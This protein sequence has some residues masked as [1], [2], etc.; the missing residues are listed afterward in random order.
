M[1][2]VFTSQREDYVRGKFIQINKEAILKNEPIVA[3]EYKLLS[4]GARNPFRNTIH[5]VTGDIYFGDVGSAVWEEINMIPNPLVNEEIVNFGW[6]CVEGDDGVSDMYQNYLRENRIDICNKVYRGDFNK[7]LFHYRFGPVDPDFP[8]YC[9]DA[10]AS[11]SGMTFYTGNKLPVNFKNSLF[12]VDYGKK[13]VFNFVNGPD[14]NPIFTQAHAI[15]AGEAGENLGGFTDIKT[16]NDGYLYVADYSGGSLHRLV[17]ADDDVKVN[18]LEEDDDE[19]IPGLKLV[20]DT[21]PGPYEW[22]YGQKVDYELH[23]NMD[24]PEDAISW[25][26]TNGHC[27]KNPC[28]GKD[29]C[30]FHSV[31]LSEESRKGSKG[32]FN[33][34][35]HPM[36]SFILITATIQ[37]NGKVVTKEFITHSLTYNYKVST[38]PEG[39]PITID[40][41]T[42][43]K[44]PCIMSQM[45]ATNV[46]FS[47]QKIQAR[48][49][50]LFQFTGWET[51][52]VSSD[53]PKKI[54]MIPT[55]AYDEIAE[56]DYVVTAV[57][58]I[59]D[60][61]VNDTIGTPEEVE[62]EGDYRKVSISWLGTDVGQVQNDEINPEYVI[63][64]INADMI[65]NPGIKED[66]SLSLVFP[67]SRDSAAIPLGPLALDYTISLAFYNAKENIL[68]PKSAPVTFVSLGQPSEV[69]KIS[70][71]GTD[72]EF[73]EVI[74]MEKKRVPLAAAEIDADGKVVDDGLIE[75]QLVDFGVSLLGNYPKTVHDNQIYKVTIDTVN[76]IDVDL[77]INLL[78]NDTFEWYGG[79]VANVKAG[80]GVKTHKFPIAEGVADKELRLHVLMIPVDGKYTDSYVEEVSS[81]IDGIEIL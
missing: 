64:Y 18:E 63:V 46:G 52:D 30:H 41:R 72:N 58:D 79:L 31:S 33:P 62:A 35:P 60:Y 4:K 10:D 81:N 17:S 77:M 14:G 53:K 45:A 26:V 37:M 34:S 56:S 55:T 21:N 22:K 5:P 59:I 23:S 11:T 47:V 3:D 20:I 42:C 80:G 29:D 43:L 38:K 66:Y 48:E 67:A 6:P 49:N 7:P 9:N 39:F 16:G 40:E 32:Y 25:R 76:A 70:D 68:G 69:N 71:C 44:S 1:G 54:D 28:T 36:E 8:D 15:V 61:E 78:D 73:N 74:K 12:M 2:G 27:V 13:C 50:F 75:G 51:I 24:I 65:N 19:G 57:Y